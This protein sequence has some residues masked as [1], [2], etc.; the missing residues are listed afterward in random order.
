MNKS[1]LTRIKLEE[2]LSRIINGNPVVIPK[3]QKISIKAVEEEAGLGS[4]TIYYYKDIV[5][6]IKQ[7]HLKSKSN[8]KNINLYE[9][10]ISSLRER[11]SKEIKLKEK[12]RHQIEVL[13]KQLS[14]MAGEHNQ[15]A[16]MIQQ[17]EYK[18]LELESTIA[19][20]RN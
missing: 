19:L 12:Y 5:Q 3:T 8:V 14:L 18:I 13:K 17:Y 16:L 10:K 9:E 15:L 11:L 2:A 7:N 6:K 4:G 1:S 20:E